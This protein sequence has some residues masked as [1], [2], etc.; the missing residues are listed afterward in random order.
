LSR[1]ATSVLIFSINWKCFMTVTSVELDLDRQQKA[2]EYAR[3][4]RRLSF[5]SMGIGVIGVFILLFTNL[6]IWLGDQLQALSWQP[7]AGWFPIQI[8]VYF[9]ILILAYEIITAPIAYYSGFVLPHSQPAKSWAVLPPLHA[10]RG[11]L[12]DTLLRVKVSLTLAGQFAQEEGYTLLDMRHDFTLRRSPINVSVKKRFYGTWVDEAYEIV[13]D[14]WLTFQKPDTSRRWI[15]LEH[16]R[17]SAS[18]NKIKKH[19]R[20]ILSFISSE[21][22]KKEFGA[23]G[24]TIAYTTSAGNHRRE[25]LR[26]LAREVLTEHLN[27]TKQGALGSAI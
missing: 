1:K 6:G 27:Q 2:K 21:G 23:S 9:L 7:I 5:V 8:L 10:V 25:R 4:R 12:L 13:A 3:I 15:W 24:V 18:A 22:Y 19:L 20:G 17:S 26:E 14:A 16:D 11:N